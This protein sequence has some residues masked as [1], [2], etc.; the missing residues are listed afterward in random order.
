MESILLILVILIV[1]FFLTGC[2]DG[3]GNDNPND[4][5]IDYSFMSGISPQYT[6]LMANNYKELIDMVSDYHGNMLRVFG[7]AGWGDAVVYK[8]CIGNDLSNIDANYI[9]RVHD[10]VGYATSKGIITIFSLFHNNG[11]PYAWIAHANGN[12]QRTYMTAVYN[13]TKGKAIIFEPL[14]EDVNHNFCMFVQNELRLL[15]PSVKTCF[16]AD[17]G[18]NYRIEHVLSKGY[19]GGGKIHSNDKSNYSSF[20]NAGDYYNIAVEAKRQGGHTEFLMAW[21]KNGRQLFTRAEIEAEYK[22]TLNLLKT[23]R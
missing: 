15:D 6:M 19:I 20:Y 18:G 3:D 12:V 7:Y 11:D 5:Q 17:N 2:D 4:N 13:A 9:Q 21:A 10:F 23:V 1:S 14:N 16:Y 22:D 8:P